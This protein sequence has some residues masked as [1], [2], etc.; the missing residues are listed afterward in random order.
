MTR[1]YNPVWIKPGTPLPKHHFS[2]ALSKIRV[3]EDTKDIG[4][5]IIQ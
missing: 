4:N 5:L 3:A 2:P 1:N